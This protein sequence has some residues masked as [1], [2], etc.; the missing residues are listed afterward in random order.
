MV[1]GISLNLMVYVL[2]G[3]TNKNKRLALGT[4]IPLPAVSKLQILHLTP[5]LPQ[6][7]LPQV[8]VV[9]GQGAL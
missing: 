5:A 8:M 3:L 7:V 1:N 2:C 6:V 4:H 9:G